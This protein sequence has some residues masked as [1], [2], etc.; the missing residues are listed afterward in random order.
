MQLMN[1]DRHA[2]RETMSDVG[3]GFLLAFPISLTVLNICNY[4]DASVLATSIA[5]TF[6]FTIFAIVRKYVIRVSFEKANKK[7]QSTQELLDAYDKVLTKHLKNEN[8]N[9]S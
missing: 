5:Q 8:Q 6:V 1:I 9:Q 7:N 4:F 2:L 3:V